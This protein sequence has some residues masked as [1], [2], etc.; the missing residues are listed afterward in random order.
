MKIN[1]LVND[2]EFEI[3]ASERE[4]ILESCLRAQVSPPYS[5]LEGICAYCQAEIIDGEVK[6]NPGFEA[7]EH[8][9]V[10][11]TCQTFPVSKTVKIKYLKKT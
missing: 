1:V 3:E 8:P 11:K 10:A 2:T 7:D 4:T 9:K 6:I 5:C